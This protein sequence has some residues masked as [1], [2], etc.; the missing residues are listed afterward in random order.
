MDGSVGAVGGFR[1]FGRAETGGWGFEVSGGQH[2]MYGIPRGMY[3]YC[4]TQV[5][6]CTYA[7]NRHRHLSTHFKRSNSIPNTSISI[8]NPQPPAAHPLQ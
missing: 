3:V 8:Y 5:D 6:N 4:A 1:G 2:S 7:H